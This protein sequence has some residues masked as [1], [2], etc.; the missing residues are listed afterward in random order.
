MKKTKKISKW[1]KALRISLWTILSLFLLL[2]AGISFLIHFIVTPEKLTPQ[3][4]QIVNE[5]IDGRFECAKAELTFFSTF[6]YL[7]V[8]IHGGKLSSESGTLLEIGSCKTTFN[9]KKLYK[10]HVIDIKNITLRNTT[11]NLSI[12]ENG[13]S[14]W[15]HIIAFKSDSTETDSTSDFTIQELHLKKLKLDNIHINYINEQTHDLLT[16]DSLT[17]GF[18]MKYLK[19]HFMCD[20]TASVPSIDLMK[21][22]IVMLRHSS[23]GI[24][25]TLDFLQKERKLIFEKGGITVNGIDLTVE[26]SLQTDTIAHKINTD[27]VLHLKAPDLRSVLALIPE[28]IIQKE[29][30]DIKGKVNFET[31][32]K[33]YYGKDDYPTTVLNMSIGDGQFKYKDYP[34]SINHIATDLNLTIDFNNK[35]KSQLTLK[36]LDVRGL[37]IGLS[38]TAKVTDLLQHPFLETKLKGNID[39]TK[40]HDVIPFHPD[41]TADGIVNLN[42]ETSFDVKEVK[43]QDL[44]SLFAKGTMIANDLNINLPKDSVS[45]KIKRL[46]FDSHYESEKVAV[47]NIQ[48]TDALTLSKQYGRLIIDSL[49]LDFK[50]NRIDSNKSTLSTKIQTGN[51][52][53]NKGR[54][55]RIKWM[56]GDITANLETYK[57]DPLKNVITSTFQLDSLGVYY[58]KRFVG[59]NNGK[60]RVK[61]QK[62]NDQQ[63][64]PMGG[65]HFTKLIAYSPTFKMPVKMENST[66]T[67]KKELIELKNSHVIFGHSDI[68]LTG[69]I[70]NAMGLSNNNGRKTTGKL[71]VQSG[72]LDANE[73]MGVFTTL[74]DNN[75]DTT[76]NDEPEIL[77]NE[78]IPDSLQEKH[79]FKLPGNLDFTFKTNINKLRYG[80]MDLEDIH[81]IVVIKD[82]NVQLSDFKMKTLAA[83]LSS[84]ITYTYL[85]EKEAEVNFE[86]NIHDIEMDKL[87]EML[88]FLDTLFPITKSFEGQV[89]FR[90]K[91]KSKLDEYLMINTPTLNGIAALQ[92]KN[93]MVF[94]SET[95]RELAKTLMFKSKEKNPIEELNMEMLIHDNKLELL[96]S[97]VEIDRYKLAVGGIQNIDFSYDYHISVLKSPIPFKTGVDV[98]GVYDNFKIRLSKAKY[99][100]Y[101]TDNERLQRKADSSVIKQKED[102]L[103]QLNF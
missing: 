14:D 18:K 55:Q 44:S 46:D 28:K 62:N 79:V 90:I 102:I 12:D 74:T 89:D 76:L 24:N 63:W 68:V 4:V 36:T 77:V 42:I 29:K 98:T 95:F 38:G 96:P 40:L 101:F 61:L 22:S 20:L 21:D 54:R 48:I 64:E 23:I 50:L 85:N 100:S 41:I 13:N 83:D 11:L 67:I 65:I 58:N 52:T 9:A 57:N 32:I 71:T 5:N 99:K 35:K 86:F 33:G 70:D 3:L 2:V 34:G 30:I 66:L 31:T 88:P 94:D 78:A 27:L 25:T 91:G 45:L 80:H 8:E 17:A 60:Y 37:G 53:Y 6:P 87:S 39:L 92:A 1:R 82:G 15:D 26:G 97:Y 81:G 51:I 56:G 10:D 75:Q 19:D 16:I 59:I 84:N 72:Y 47:G 103:N 73:L 69:F 49:G 93:I 7:G 43:E